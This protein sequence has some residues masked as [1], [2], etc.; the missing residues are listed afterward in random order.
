MG[1]SKYDEEAAAV[2]RA[3]SV[4]EDEAGA[5]YEEPKVRRAIVHTRQDVVIVVSYLSSLNK[6]VRIVKWLIILVVLML[7]VIASKMR[8]Q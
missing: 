1:R 7:I 2:A 8:P 5:D 3:V 4:G 6:Q